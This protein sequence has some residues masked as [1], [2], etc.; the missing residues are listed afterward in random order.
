VI[1]VLYLGLI[2]MLWFDAAQRMRE[3]QRFRARIE[4]Q[5][6]AENAAELAAQRMVLASS[7]TVDAE[8]PEGIMTGS[9]TRFADDTFVI[10]GRG[11]GSRLLRYEARVTIYGRVNGA[12][13]EIERT[14]HWP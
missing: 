4:A 10:E 14:R 8:L 5:T 6:L 7:A 9:M 11:K 3:A 1:A 13:I 12:D 2:E